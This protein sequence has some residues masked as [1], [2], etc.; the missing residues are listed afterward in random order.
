MM[1][2]ISALLFVLIAALALSTAAMAD[3]F[4]PQLTVK[5]SA[6]RITVTLVDTESNSE[7]P[8]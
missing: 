3:E 8:L 6:D 4:D 7:P 2:R 1:K 5:R